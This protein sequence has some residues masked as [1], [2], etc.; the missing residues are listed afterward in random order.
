MAYFHRSDGTRQP[1]E[2]IG[3][4]CDATISLQ[5]VAAS[6]AKQCRFNGHTKTFYSVA[7][8]S[9]LVSEQVERMIKSSGTYGFSPVAKQAL[10]L[11]ALLHDAGEAITGDIISPIKELLSSH[12]VTD[13]ED[14]HR[15]EMNKKA[16]GNLFEHWRNPLIKRA[17]LDLL[18]T[19]MVALLNVEASETTEYG[20][21]V[22]DHL[23]ARI[24]TETTWREDMSM[25]LRRFDELGGRRW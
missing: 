4:Y 12:V 19:E 2:F 6:L 18:C 14:S 8:H 13:I 22:L 10:S 17:D 7:H 16:N 23:I 21:V 25:F 11:S 1:V 5:E 24:A 15:L 3:Q 20:G 9:V